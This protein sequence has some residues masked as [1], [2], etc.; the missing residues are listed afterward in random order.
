MGRREDQ[1][2]ILKSSLRQ[3]EDNQEKRNELEDYLNETNDQR[4]KEMLEK[5]IKKLSL[6]IREMI[7]AT[8]SYESQ[9]G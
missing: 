2:A 4:T 3:I 5:V 6:K 7:N 1:Q 8:K 9:I